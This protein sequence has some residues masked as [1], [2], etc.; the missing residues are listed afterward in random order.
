MFVLDEDGVC[1]CYEHGTNKKSESQTG[2]KTHGL[3]DTGALTKPLSY[4][5]LLVNLAIN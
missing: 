4:E 1:I 2:I 3:P 5:I